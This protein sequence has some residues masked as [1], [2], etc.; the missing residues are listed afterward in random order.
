[1]KNTNN[2]K[3]IYF[4]GGCFWGV[5]EYF[6]RI[7]GVNDATSGYA[8]GFTDNPTYEEVCSGN[9]G[10]TETVQVSYDPA[11]V[12]LKTLT[13]Q[14]FKI[15]DPTSVNKQGNDRGSQYRS[16]IYYVD[17]A[18]KK[19]IQ[20]VFDEAQKAYADKVV[21]ELYPLKR[22]YPAESYHQDYLEKNPGGYCHIDFSSL[23]D[24]KTEEPQA[25]KVDPAKYQKPS[26]DEIEAMLTPGQYEVTQ[27]SATE[28]PFGNEYFSN[29]KAGIYVDIVTGEP[30]FSSA[31]KYDSGCGWPSFTKPIDPEVSVEYED[32]SHGMIRTEVRSRVGDSH[33]GHVFNDGPKEKGGLRYCTNSRA[34]RFIPYEKMAEEG[35]GEFMSLCATYGE[36]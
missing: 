13:E 3:H 28:P 19:V 36:G 29:H 25:T 1:M 21:T 23:N 10:Y 15:I 8:N 14:F 2:L 33:L 12:S 16:G 32:T 35:Y 11:I 26:D 22:Y 17:E 34:L 5:E 9:T 24:I 18:D 30:L 7:P 4:A 27:Q 6:S 20:A 31:D